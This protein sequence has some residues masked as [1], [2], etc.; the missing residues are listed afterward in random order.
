MS[1][2]KLQE[3]PEQVAMWFAAASCF[4]LLS[5]FNKLLIL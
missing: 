1:E 5:S 2:Q 3:H 4:F